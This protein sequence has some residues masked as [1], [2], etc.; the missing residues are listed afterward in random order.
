MICY[1]DICFCCPSESCAITECSRH[2]NRIREYQRNIKLVDQLP[3]AMTDF[4]TT[5]EA[6]KINPSNV[7]PESTDKE[8]NNEQEASKY[9]KD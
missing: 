8:K 6:Y 7:T 2:I 9:S 4:S 5:C 3:V 1:K